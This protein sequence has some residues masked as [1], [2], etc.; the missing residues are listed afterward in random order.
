MK[1]QISAINRDFG[2]ERPT[3]LMGLAFIVLC[4]LPMLMLRLIVSA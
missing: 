3:C 4:V 2:I 1:S